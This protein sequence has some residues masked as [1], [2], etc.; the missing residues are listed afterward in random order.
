M[1]FNTKEICEK[2]IK[3][4]EKYDK[5][6]FSDIC[7]GCPLQHHTMCINTQGAL[8]IDR[9]EIDFHEFMKAF[10]EMV[11]IIGGADE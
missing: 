2:G 10:Y 5:G 3:Y 9:R 1:K 11:K 7:D 4:C 6:H 8:L